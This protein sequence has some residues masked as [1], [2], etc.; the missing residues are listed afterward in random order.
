[1]DKQDLIDKINSVYFYHRIDLGNGIVTPGWSPLEP[2]KYGI[3]E[4]MDGESV[5]DVGAWDGY[6]TF[7]SVKRGASR[8]LAIDDFS[9]TCGK[10]INADRSTQWA[11]FDLCRQALGIS[12]DIAV[13]RTDSIERHACVYGICDRVFMFGVLYHLKNPILAL[14]NCFQSLRPGGTIHVETAILDGTRSTYTGQPANPMGCYAEFFPNDEFG[15]NSS[16]WWVPT[17]KCAAS[18]LE[19]VGFV[20]IESW[21]L[22]SAPRTL[23]ECRGFLRAKKPA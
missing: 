19:A 5:L 9:D 15:K 18:W 16:N 17:L 8:V 12:E 3:P 4:R 1:M 2:E 23:A 10:G 11:N 21:K 7:E 20:D 6:W 14:S 13:R 22:K